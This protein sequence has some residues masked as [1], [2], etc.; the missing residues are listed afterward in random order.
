MPSRSSKTHMD[1]ETNAHS[2][3]AG[4]IPA[5]KRTSPVRR[6][7]PLIIL[8]AGLG[9]FFA[10]GGTHLFSFETLR[11]NREA[12]LGWRDQNFLAAVFAYIALYAVVTAFSLPAGAVL[13]LAGGFMF[14]WFWGGLMVITGATIGAVALFSVARTALGEPLRSKAGPFLKKFEA[15]FK[16]DMWSYLIILRLVPLF[17]FWLVNL[18]PA[19]LGVPLGAYA[20]TTFFGIMPGTFV[21]AS[22]GAGLGTV[23]DRGATP[24][25]G[26]VLAD[27]NVYL[28]IAGLIALAL[29]PVVYKRLT[30]NKKSA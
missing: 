28:P 1:Q 26:V 29:I 27:P 10:F 17:P 13:S 21:F 9:A 3:A 16:E 22:V 14:G 4:G 19:F 24:D 25:L 6:F 23:F 20:V 2:E 18:A 8:I 5:G 11:D 7:L 30:T 12:L 15:G